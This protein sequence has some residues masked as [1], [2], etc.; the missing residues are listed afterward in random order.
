MQVYEMQAHEVPAKVRYRAI[1]Y[2]PMG[3]GPRAI[4]LVRYTLSK[5]YAY[6]VHAYGIHV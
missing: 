3:G 1:R 5:V 6:G 4:R 2:T